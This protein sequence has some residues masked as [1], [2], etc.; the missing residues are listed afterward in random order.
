MP[1]GALA[2][3]LLLAEAECTLPLLLLLA[4]ALKALPLLALLLGMA[5]TGC[6]AARDAM[7]SSRALSL[8]TAWSWAPAASNLL[9]ML[10]WRAG[11]RWERGERGVR[12]GRRDMNR[13]TRRGS[14]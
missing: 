5:A 9:L 8:R 7:A 12:R 2:V 11:G 6:R 10:P 3:L 1:E 14:T 13:R 4:L